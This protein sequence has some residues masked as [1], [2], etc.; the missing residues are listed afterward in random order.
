MAWSIYT[1]AALGDVRNPRPLGSCDRCGFVYNLDRL[2]WQYTWAGQSIR[3]DGMLVCPTCMDLPQQQ[4]RAIT[5]PIDP[6]PIVNPRPGEYGG[7]V[8][9]SS[10]EVFATIVPSPIVVQSSAT[11][12][13]QEIGD[14]SPL[15]TQNSSLLIVTETTV[16]PNPDPNYGD[17][18]YTRMTGDST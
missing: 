15:V 8:I 1:H 5:I 9:S 11:D 16:T 2:K 17:G 18:G 6:V 12:G 7:M 13:T 3:R 10:P 14:R 4:L